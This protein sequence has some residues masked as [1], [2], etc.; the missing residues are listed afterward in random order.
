MATLSNILA[1]KSPWTEK[2]GRLQSVGSQTVEHN[3]LTNYYPSA[4]WKQ[5]YLVGKCENAGFKSL[6]V[7]GS[8]FILPN[9]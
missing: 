9:V 1:W 8:I 6:M 2:P 3:L 7:P 4:S 5:Y